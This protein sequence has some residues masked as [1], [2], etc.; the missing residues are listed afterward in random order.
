MQISDGYLIVRHPELQRTLEIADR[1][2]RELRLY[3]G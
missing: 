2:G 1:V 3:A